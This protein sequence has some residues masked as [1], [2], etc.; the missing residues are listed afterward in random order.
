MHK[1][2][3]YAAAVLGA[4]F[5]ITLVFWANSGAVT[6]STAGVRS[7]AAISPHEIMR[8]STNLPVQT[9]RDPF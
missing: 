4:L 9:V 2:V 1:Y 7:G 8:G 6:T 3:Q 5:V